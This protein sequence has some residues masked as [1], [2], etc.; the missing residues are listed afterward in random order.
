MKK[1]LVINLGWEQKPLIKRLAER[2]D[3]ILYGVHYDNSAEIP[4]VFQSIEISDLRDMESILDFAKKIKPDAVISDQ[5]D[6]S[7][8]AQ[9]LV[10]EKFNLPSPSVESAQLSNNKYLQRIKSKENSILIPEFKLCTKKEDIKEFAD[11]FS[12]PVI[13]KPIDNRGSF[14]VVKV[15]S[16]DEIQ[17]AFTI[18]V[19][20]S[21]SRMLLVEQFINGVHYIVDGLNIHS[22]H[23]SFAVGKKKLGKGGFMHEDILYLST[24]DEL[25]K[26]LKT[27]NNNNILKL[28]YVFGC[29]SSEYIIDEDNRIFLVE[30]SNRGGGVFISSHVV[31]CISGIDAVNAYISEALGVE[32]YPIKRINQLSC[33][34]LVYFVADKSGI[35]SHL[36]TSALD[37]S[38]VLA[39]KIWKKV[40]DKVSERIDNAISRLG[41]AL[42]ICKHEGQKIDLKPKIRIL[43]SNKSL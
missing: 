31:N 7:L 33:V 30:S 16:E 25:T 27:H 14:G 34:H 15:N 4:E 17:E 28:G 41:F 40:G 35:I 18:A 38:K 13:V 10:A 23:S 26:K 29:T 8:M 21:H 37:N 3:C 20:N 32:N 43:Q 42:F 6:Y 12:Y 39:Y 11:K 9:A 19:V 36:D 5:C 2:R 1:V 24:D 22:E